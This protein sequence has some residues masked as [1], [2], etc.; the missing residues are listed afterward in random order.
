MARSW[1]YVCTGWRIAWLVAG[2][3]WLALPASAVVPGEALFV[4]A[5]LPLSQGHIGH[6][7]VLADG[8]VVLRGD[9]SSVDGILRP[10]LA[11][12]TTSGA[13]DLAFQPA[14][15]NIS[16]ESAIWLNGWYFSG[17]V[18]RLCEMADGTLLQAVAGQILAYDRE[19]ALDPRFSALLQADG[20]IEALFETAGRLYIVRGGASGR[21]LEAY[22][23]DSIESIIL[24]S[25]E[26][27]PMALGGVVPASEG[28]LWILGQEMPE[29]MVWGWEIPRYSLF[30][31][32]ADGFLD[33]SFEPLE[34]PEYNY[35]S[36][37]ARTGG[38]FRLVGLYSYGE[39]LWPS[40]THRSYGI[41]LYDAGGLLVRSHGASL[42]RGVPLVVAE[43]ADGALL[44]NQVVT[45]LDG[46]LAEQQKNVLIRIRPDGEPDPSFCVPLGSDSPH[47]LPDGRIQL[48]GLRRVRA[49]GTPDPEWQIPAV[50]GEPDVTIIGQFADGGIVIREN[51]PGAQNGSTGL[52]A[53]DSDLKQD[54]TFQPPPDLPP[55]LSVQ[56]TRDGHALV[57]AL[58]SCYEFPDDT[59]S[60][61]IRLLRDGSVDPDSPRYLPAGSWGYWDGIAGAMIPVA[62][63]GNFG[64]SPLSD[65]GFLIQYQVDAG[66]VWR[67]VRQR[68]RVDGSEDAGFSLAIDSYQ[69]SSIFVLSDDRLIARKALYAANGSFERELAFPEQSQPIL[70]LPDGRL[71]LRTWDENA[72]QL[73]LM[74]MQT[75][76][77]AVFRT[78][79]CDGTRIGQVTPVPG[80]CWIVAGNLQTS[81]G[82][83]AQVRLLPDGRVDPTFRTAELARVVPDA[84]NLQGVLRDGQWVPPT[85]PNRSVAAGMSSMLPLP[86]EDALLVGGNFSHVGG[87]PM[88][89]LAKLSLR[90]INTFEEWLDALFPEWREEDEEEQAI[91]L[92][93]RW[94][95]YALGLA[96]SV[97]AP[98]RGYLSAAPGMPKA[99]RL[100]IN[101]AA[102]DT[103][104]VVETSA[105]LENWRTASMEE[106][107][108]ARDSSGI[109]VEYRGA[110]PAGFLRVRCRK[111]P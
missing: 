69:Y 101:P 93:R 32:D 103:D 3:G 55:V 43:E 41:G 47:V 105:D 98:P 54:A 12:L 57:L 71:L 13:E 40:A 2:L 33:S 89:G 52:R 8:S 24:S 27:W 61:L 90:Q 74:D 53:L 107:A 51:R 11:I 91:T 97:S 111:I 67:N 38:G 109:M 73:A 81:A 45:E 62:Y 66:D 29:P 80:G 65:G 46:C 110:Q 42:P 100:P 77:D 59:Q 9:F 23:A 106:V 1:Q 50:I 30:R 104:Y 79:F 56:M 17:S 68:L 7:L 70:E 108:I 14:A 88:P 102:N 18:V 21:H 28:R 6:W 63:A 22:D 95:S 4:D 37:A 34:L 20:V 82:G 83:Q 94:A 26:D 84:P 36:I 72:Q 15:V 64:V 85:L 25:Q 39:W 75:G 58:G 31:V 44:C 19:G 35:Y 10:G 96:P 60:R 5:E 16:G 49:D 48:S 87:E 86:A 92:P 78:E 76:L 99:F